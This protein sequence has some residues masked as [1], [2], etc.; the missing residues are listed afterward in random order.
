MRGRYGSVGLL[1]LCMSSSAGAQ[2]ADVQKIAHLLARATFGVRAQDVARVQAMGVNRWLGE[3][4]EPGRIGDAAVAAKLADFATLH[5]SVPELVQSFPAGQQKR[6]STMQMRQNPRRILLELVGARIVRAT[7]SERQLEEV[8]TEFWFNH[9]NVF[10][11]KGP[12][13]YLVADYE[14]RAIRPFV[15][16]KFAD[17]LQATAQ[18][19][20]MLIYLDNAQ[21]NAR[22]GVNENYARELM[23]LHTLGV[24]GGY[25]QKDVQEVA[26]A[27]TGWTVQRPAG[28]RFAR[29]LHDMDEKVVLG[30]K[31]PAGRGIE[32]GRD[33]LRM[34]AHNPATAQH[35]ARELVEHF[36]S[37]QPS[38]EFVAELAGVF[39][40][41]DGDLRAVT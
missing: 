18:H 35:I 5:M 14:D 27:F 34:L 39:L 21:S 29:Q 22:R 3:Q 17:M 23:E 11:G 33:V 26:R 16:G 15:F 30:I 40:K 7:A 25:T 2:G 38:P 41:T 4:L 28:F 6:D 12:L 19:P 20:A 1:L 36:V 37:D 13:R 24:D 32:D 31:L 8:M 9:F 10:W